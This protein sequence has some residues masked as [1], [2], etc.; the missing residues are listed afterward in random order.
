MHT[1]FVFVSRKTPQEAI[2]SCKA[3]V[4]IQTLV[5]LYHIWFGHQEIKALLV[6]TVVEESCHF[7]CVIVF[8][9]ERERNQT[10]G[11]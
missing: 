8:Q 1:L 10:H 4:V 7:M 3:T 5:E 6:M 2:S 11:I 9:E